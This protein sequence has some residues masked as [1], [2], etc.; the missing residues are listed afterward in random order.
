MFLIGNWKMYGSLPDLE[1]FLSNL[2]TPPSYVCPILCL[3][4][5]YLDYAHRMKPKFLYIGGQDCAAVNFGPLTGQ[6]SAVMLREVGCRYAIV[7]HPERHESDFEV[8]QKA[9]CALKSELTPIVCLSDPESCFQRIPEAERLKCLVAYEPAVGC[10]DLPDNLPENAS[11]LKKYFPHVLYG[12]GVN[13]RTLPY[14]KNIFDG[15]LVGR[16][17]L[18]V[19]QWNSLIQLL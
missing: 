12:G 4:S 19:H 6:I 13:S 8:A 3:P 15:F 14:L 5:I 2:R 18:D 11:F 1:F 16:A 7:G 17:S 9:L 10:T